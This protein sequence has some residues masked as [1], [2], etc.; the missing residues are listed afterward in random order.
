MPAIASPS[1]SAMVR[2][3]SWSA[4]RIL[5]AAIW[6][7]LLSGAKRVGCSYTP[8]T[9]ALRLRLMM[10]SSHFSSSEKFCDGVVNYHRLLDRN[11]VAGIGHDFEMCTL[12]LVPDEFRVFAPGAAVLAAQDQGRFFY[13]GD[14]TGQIDFLARPGVRVADPRIGLD[15][16]HPHFADHVEIFLDGLGRKSVGHEGLR[17]AAHHDR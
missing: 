15:L 16:L 3:Q 17:R 13:R 4:P 1:T 10:R 7:M 11:Q 12:D 6:N 14:G 8:A 9:Q 5:S 2:P